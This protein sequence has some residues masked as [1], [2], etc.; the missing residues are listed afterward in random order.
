M[1][2][3]GAAKHALK[4]LGPKP[5]LLLPWQSRNPIHQT[6]GKHQKRMTGV[7][8]VWDAPQAVRKLPAHWNSGPNPS[9]EDEG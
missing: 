8:R 5:L 3:S 2:E 6:P 9:R 4:R 1:A 7:M